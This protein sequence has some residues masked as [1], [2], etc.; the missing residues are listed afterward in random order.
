MQN[1]TTDPSTDNID[2]KN[3]FPENFLSDLSNTDEILFDITETP[4]APASDDA[5]PQTEESIA[6]VV[7]DM[8]VD[9][10]ILEKKED[11]SENFTFEELE[12]ELSGSLPLRAAENLIQQSPKPI[13]DLIEYSMTLGPD[14]T[15]DQLQ[16][17]FELSKQQSSEPSLESLSDIDNARDYVAEVLKE[18][19]P[20]IDDDDLDNLL[21]AMEQ[22]SKLLPKAE[23]LYNKRQAAKQAEK[24][25]K[26]DENKAAN[27]RRQAAIEKFQTNF[28][29]E[30]KNT[31]WAKTRQESIQSEF[32]SENIDSK[33]KTI[34]NDPKAFVHFLN[35]LSYYNLENQSFNFDDFTKSFNTAEKQQQNVYADRFKI[36]NSKGGYIQNL[37]GQPSKF[38]ENFE[39]L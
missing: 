32:S 1:N 18:N 17:F 10:A 14:A 35:F 30:I 11:I 5:P 23:E 9:K 4:S 39:I 22:K 28:K 19:I 34:Y 2:D 25:R 38:L 31:K 36:A 24:Q 27:Q 33:L 15:L 13:R 12:T 8:L 7:Y 21:E 26:I 16:D 6:R 3:D 37:K 29:N 20:G